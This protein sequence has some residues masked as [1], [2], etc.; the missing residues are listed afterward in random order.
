MPQPTQVFAGGGFR[1]AKTP[2]ACSGR[3]LS[4]ASPDCAAGTRRYSSQRDE[5]HHQLQPE[6][7]AFFLEAQSTCSKL[8][9]SD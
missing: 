2:S 5:F 4:R 3:N 1:A 8:L 9:D 6:A 7:D